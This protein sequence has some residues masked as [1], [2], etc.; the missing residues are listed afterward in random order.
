PYNAV[1]VDEAS[2]MDLLLTEALLRALKPGTRLIFVGDRDQLPSVGA[3]NVLSD[4]IESEYFQVTKLNRIY[5]QG[6][7]SEII[8]NA[9][10]VNKGEYPGYEE[11]KGDSVPESDFLLYRLDKQDDIANMIL[12]VSSHFDS[13]DVQVLT[14]VKKGKL[15][16]AELNDRLHEIF[17][18]KTEEKDEIPF[19]KKYFRV[20]DR[21][22]QIKNN[23]RILY[24]AFADSSFALSNN[25]LQSLAL[26][27][28]AE[29]REVREGQG[30]FNGEIGIVTAVDKKKRSVTV[31]YDNERY[32][33]Y[34]YTDLD[35]IE[36]A[37]AITIHKSQGSEF[38]VVVIPMSWFPPVISTRSLI[39]TG[40]TRGK[41]KVMIVGNPEYMN[42]MVDNNESG[43]RNSGLRYRL[44]SLLFGV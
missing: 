36:H 6:S 9:H 3:G 12:D 24:M 18:P 41:E 14:P 30:V 1:I 28:I 15:G 17:N 10:R 34:E 16:T 44:S 19:G 42:A 38:P 33:E 7:D 27:D 31:I 5:R 26:K 32:V 35:E 8:S 4:M 22:M 23:Y 20:G 43:R 25:P 2:M 40:I 13:N 21:V 11:V 29:N 37:Y 39:Y